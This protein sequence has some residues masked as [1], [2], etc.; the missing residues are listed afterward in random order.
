MDPIGVYRVTCGDDAHATIEP[1]FR[2]KSCLA[3]A[4]CR[5]FPRFAWGLLHMKL[6]TNAHGGTESVCYLTL[7]H[8]SIV[9]SRL[10]SPSVSFAS[11][12]FTGELLAFAHSTGALGARWFETAR[13]AV[14]S[15][16]R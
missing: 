9:M 16:T 3:G 13:R 8:A 12:D 6:R 2:G 1:N 7:G 10:A 4:R 14:E 5:V 15:R 11:E